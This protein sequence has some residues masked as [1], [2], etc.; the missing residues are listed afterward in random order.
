M[1]LISRSTK[2]ISIIELL[3][4]LTITAVV[5]LG[6]YRMMVM[7]YKA[8]RI[9]NDATNQ[10]FALQL[11]NIVAADLQQADAS[12][13]P[14]P[15]INAADGT[16]PAAA[17]ITRNNMGATPPYTFVQYAFV[18]AGGGK[19]RLMRYESS[20]IP[21]VRGPKTTIVS[22]SIAL[23]GPGNPLPDGSPAPLFFQ[24][25]PANAAVMIVSVVYEP[26][27]VKLPDGRQATYLGSRRVVLRN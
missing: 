27:D 17:W 13:F 14:F 5:L 21:P 18:P 15:S 2:G 16:L 23:P 6:A 3:I 12:S 25:D 22:D 26:S 11:L 1:S 24:A 20:S 19:A 8:S 10:Q 4:A 7:P 9:L